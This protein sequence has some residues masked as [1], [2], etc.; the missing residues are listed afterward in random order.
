MVRGNGQIVFASILTPQPCT[1]RVRDGAGNSQSGVTV[2]WQ[3]QSGD[4]NVTIASAVTDSNGRAATQFGLGTPFYN[5]AFNG[6]KTS[7]IRA[8]SP[9]GNVD[10]TV[11]SYPQ[12]GPP[13]LL[14]PANP[15]NV[16]LIGPAE[17]TVI[18]VQ[19]GTTTVGVIKA[20]IFSGT[21]AGFG[22]P[23]VGIGFSGTT[24]NEADS[25]PTAN[26]S[27]T[28]LSNGQGDVV[29]DIVA[30]PKLG[31]AP[32]Q[33]CV[34]NCAI[35]GRQFNYLLE[36]T[37]GPPGVITKR[38]GDNQ[39]GGPGTLT[40]LALRGTVTDSFG[41]KLQGVQVRV[42]VISGDATIES[43]FNT[44]NSDGDFS[45][46]VRFGSTPGEVKI[47]TSAGNANT[48]WTL[49]NN[50]TIGNFNKVN[51]DNQTAVIGRPFTTPLSVQLFDAQGRAISG[52]TVTFAVQS[53]SATFSDSSA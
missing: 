7:V 12:S 27:Q 11:I 41:N 13:P 8:S 47:R 29:C 39:S 2:T 50:V 37:A 32:F 48:T 53:G 52:A 25:G 18:K 22:S 23:I 21:L 15:P 24:G 20:Q 26:C 51:G 28:N 36:V 6:P 35:P 42:E 40:P 1:V 19:A 44:T 10:F 9:N 45:F 30:G 31:Q 4:G 34:G 3:V 38:Q 14:I 46:M 17:G 49:T 16:N 43:L 33:A 5:D